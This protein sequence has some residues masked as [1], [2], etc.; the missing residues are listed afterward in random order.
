MQF[1]GKYLGLLIIVVGGLFLISACEKDLDTDP[2]GDP[3]DPNNPNPTTPV[4]PEKASEYLVLDNATKIN[5]KPAPSLDGQIQMDVEDTIFVVK[6]FPVGSR[7]EFLHDPSQDISGFYVYV[8]GASAYFDVPES[9]VDGQYEAKGEE[10]TT[11]VLVLDLDP[12]VDTEEVNYPYHVEI[13]I[14]PHDPA[15]MGLDSISRVITV[16]EPIDPS[17]NSGLCNTILRT[18]GTSD[19]IW[20]WEFS[21]REYNGQILNIQAPGLAARINPQ[22][23][24]C[25]RD[26]GVS[27]T[28]S[29]SPGCVPPPNGPANNL[30]WVV[31]EV[32]D[33]VVL[34]YELAWFWENGE[35]T[36]L[37]EENKRQYDRS[38]TNF[39]TETVGYTHDLTDYTHQGTHDFVAGSDHMNLDITDSEGGY[40][41]ARSMDLIYTCN[42]L[43]VQWGREDNWSKV[44]K[45]AQTEGNDPFDFHK[46]Y[47]AWFD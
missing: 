9:I 5:G 19:R 1:T 26:D 41:P 14:Q 33:Y 43:I 45:L 46:F 38:T 23:S 20:E 31:L 32:D 8:K 2:Q 12:T 36:I 37:G 10:D 47:K 7:L 39:C 11:S 3:N 16:E 6:G 22:G 15:G 28:T 24:G 42:T 25:C 18:D 27:V 4:D 21:V 29:D 34:T 13:V 17:D 35:F 44:Y 40:R 30:T